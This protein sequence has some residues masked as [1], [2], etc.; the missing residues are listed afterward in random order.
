MSSEEANTEDSVDSLSE[1]SCEVIPLGKVFLLF[2]LTTRDI[3]VY[4]YTHIPFIKEKNITIYRCLTIPRIWKY[5][6]A[7]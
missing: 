4:V 3:K 7:I 2:G 6:S 5:P 1:V